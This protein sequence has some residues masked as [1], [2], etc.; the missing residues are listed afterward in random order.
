VKL[1]RRGTPEPDRATDDQPAEAAP[2]SSGRGSKGRPTP[3]RRDIV[4]QRGPVR[5]PQTRKEAYAR[6]KQLAREARTAPR[7]AGAR[8]TPQQRRAMLRAGD[9]SVLPRRDR[10]ESRKLARDFVDSHRMASNYLLLLFPL[11]I[12]S[13]VVR[14]VVVQLVVL[15]A[16]VGF[17]VEWY[18][19]GRR[20][21]RMAI[22]RFGKA[23]GNAL[24][25]GAYAGT[26][27][28]L[29]RKWRLPA[30]QVDL[31]DEI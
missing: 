15:A 11:M 1:L 22:E 27:A 18:F 28:Y 25:L 7:A 14:S 6:Q 2:S 24:G 8:L 16:F 19:T 12:V 21:R 26:R 10:G 5:A 9:P 4:G 23:E 20:I 30:P 31:G 17:V 29:P 3:K 13:Y